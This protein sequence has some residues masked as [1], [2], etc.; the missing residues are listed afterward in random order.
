MVFSV[1]N[2]PGDREIYHNPRSSAVVDGPVSKVCS[3]MLMVATTKVIS[4]LIRSGAGI[5]VKFGHM[6]Y[7]ANSSE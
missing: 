4:D 7:W 5:T 3:F 6:L 2:N 1:P